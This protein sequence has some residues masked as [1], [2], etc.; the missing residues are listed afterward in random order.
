ME[1]YLLNPAVAPVMTM[2][3]RRLTAYRDGLSFQ[4]PG[5][6]MYC[7]SWDVATA[8]ASRAHAVLPELPPGDANA[9]AWPDDDLLVGVRVRVSARARWWE[10]CYP[11]LRAG[12]RRRR[13]VSTPL[14]GAG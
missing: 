14:H 5:G 2:I 7:L 11:H 12:R 13:A 1:Q 3:G 10:R 6:Q 4:Y 9:N 8:F